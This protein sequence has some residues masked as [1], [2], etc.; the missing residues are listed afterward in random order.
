MLY[1]HV[2]GNLMITE[3]E[4]NKDPMWEQPTLIKSSIGRQLKFRYYFLKNKFKKIKIDKERFWVNFFIGIAFFSIIAGLII[5]SVFLIKL[6]DYYSIS[7]DAIQLDKTG[8]VGDFIGGIVGAIWTLTGVLLFYATLRLQSRELKE[9]RIHFQLSR[10]TDIVYKQLDMFNKQLESFELKDIERDSE[11]LHKKYNG[12]SAVALLAKRLEAILDI[13]KKIDKV[14]EK[15]YAKKIVGENFAF[16]EINKKEF[17]R[18]Y[19]ELGNHIDTVRAILIK[20]GIPLVDLNELKAIFFR[21][22][23]RGFLNSSEIL[24]PI[25]D[26]YIDF[27]KRTDKEFDEFWSVESSIKSNINSIIEFRQ[28]YYDKKTIKQYLDSRDLYNTHQF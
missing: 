5:F 20:E 2:G 11:G 24:L 14:D 16:I 7:G 6:S 27:K 21:N 10:L 17:L 22:V 4:N 23:G 3:Q 15:E 26:G 13:Q 19:E 9:N 18:I 28:K 8:Q 25:L 1:K 12:R